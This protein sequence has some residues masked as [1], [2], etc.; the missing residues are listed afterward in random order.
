MLEILKF[1]LGQAYQHL[2]GHESDIPKFTVIVAQKNHHTKLFQ[3]SGPEN[4]PAG[5][6]IFL[7]AIQLTSFS[8]IGIIF[9][10]LQ[11]QVLLWTPKLFILEI[12]ISICALMQG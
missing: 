2:E 5:L 12:M 7:L 9:H 1:L 4:V 3:A 8:N 10:F 11:M 6:F